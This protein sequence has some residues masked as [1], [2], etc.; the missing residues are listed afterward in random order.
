M[1]LLSVIFVVGLSLWIIKNPKDFSPLQVGK[2]VSGNNVAEYNFFVIKKDLEKN[3]AAAVYYKKNDNDQ[4]Q[5]VFLAPAQLAL[6]NQKKFFKQIPCGSKRKLTP[7]AKKLL[8]KEGLLESYRK[9]LKSLTA[10]NTKHLIKDPLP[11][12]G[13]L[14]QYALVEHFI[15]VGYYSLNPPLIFASFILD[16]LINFKGSVVE[17]SINFLYTL[18]VNPSPLVALVL[19]ESVAERHNE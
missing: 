8:E 4:D 17:H 7:R 18:P 9:A 1:R 19:D 16:N 2:C 3:Q 15:N 12:K 10:A 6:N 14:K 11:L 5:M 13:N